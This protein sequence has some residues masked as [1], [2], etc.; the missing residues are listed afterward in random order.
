MSLFSNFKKPLYEILRPKS[1][2]EF[3]GQSHLVGKDGIISLYLEHKKIFSMVFYGPPGTGK[4]TL[5]RLIA[6]ELEANFLYFNAVETSTTFIKN[7]IKS[8]CTAE[9]NILF[10][11]EIHR[12]NKSQQAIF[13]PY[14]ETGQII[15]IGAT[16][17]NPLYYI[18]PPLRSRVKF[19]EFK[20]LK[21]NELKAL[22]LKGC[23]YYKTTLKEEEIELI[24]EFSGG[25]G[26]YALFLFEELYFLLQK[27]DYSLSEL[28]DKLVKKMMPS[29]KDGDYFYSRLSALHKSL[30]GSDADAVIYYIEEMLEAGVDPRAILRRMLVMASEDIG[31]ADMNALRVVNEAYKTFEILGMPEG[32]LA[33]LQAAVYLSL[34]PKSNSI[35]LADKKAKELL[36]KKHNREVP[37]NISNHHAGTYKYPHLFDDYLI[38]QQY[39]PY[40]IKDE[41]ILEL[42]DKGNEKKF[43]ERWTFIKNKI[44]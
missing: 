29:D 15:L 44:R 36:E 17:E 1:L 33:I 25:D 30:R 42:K 21:E 13:L 39:L 7:E 41:T 24:V 5:A 16:T 19:F 23:D 2:D 35:Y 12:F 37:K 3:L 31:L 43:K 9:V 8:R 28:K 20:Y 27:K 22:I 26:R 11:D 14:I 18:I 32:R 10:V 4:T 34:T 40:D 6:K 38:K